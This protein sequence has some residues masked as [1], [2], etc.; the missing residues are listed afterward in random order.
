[1][2]V[3]LTQSARR[4]GCE[5]LSLPMEPAKSWCRPGAQWRRPEA[6]PPRGDHA[7]EAMAA[8]AGPTSG[9]LCEP[10]AGLNALI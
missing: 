4:Y 7:V 1:M 5:P 3:D 10:A 6:D 8:V 9:L 2:T